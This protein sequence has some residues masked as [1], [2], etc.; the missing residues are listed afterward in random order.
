MN[1]QITLHAV[2]T[3]SWHKGTLVFFQKNFVSTTEFE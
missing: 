2:L 1:F 3:S